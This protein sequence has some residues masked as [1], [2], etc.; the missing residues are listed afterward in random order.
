MYAIRSYYELLHAPGMF[1]SPTRYQVDDP[2]ERR[3]VARFAQAAGR[4]ADV[5]TSYSI[6]YTKLYEHRSW[7]GVE[8]FHGYAA[9][10]FAG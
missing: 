9:S 7:R 5:I 1:F 4:L 6:H 8:T 3:H 2:R 10:T